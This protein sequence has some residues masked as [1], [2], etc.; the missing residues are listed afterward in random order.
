V[1]FTNGDSGAAL[2]SWLFRQ[3]MNEDPSVFYWI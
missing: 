3:L 1:F 2:Y